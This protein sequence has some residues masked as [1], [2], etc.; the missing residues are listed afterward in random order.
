MGAY[1]I[2]KFF[3]RVFIPFI[4][5]EK[6]EKIKTTPKWKWHGFTYQKNSKKYFYA[7]ALQVIGL[8]LIMVFF[9]LIVTIIHNAN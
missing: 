8:L 7:E 4:G 1:Y 2:G 6:L 9:V 3:V 5:V